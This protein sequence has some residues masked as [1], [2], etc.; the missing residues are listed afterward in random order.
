MR[1]V[2]YKRADMIY[3]EAL[4]ST[5]NEFGRGLLVDSF[6]YSAMTDFAQ[7]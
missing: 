1:E 5:S 4:H 7:I 6:E 3:T 2:D